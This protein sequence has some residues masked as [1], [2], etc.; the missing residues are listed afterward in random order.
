MI[1]VHDRCRATM[2]VA[3]MQ[4]HLLGKMVE[5]FMD[6]NRVRH[7]ITTLTVARDHRQDFEEENSIDQRTVVAIGIKCHWIAE[8]DHP[9]R[10]QH[11]EGPAQIF[12][13]I[14]GVDVEDEVHSG[15]EVQ[16]DRTL[17][18]A[19]A[20]MVEAFHHRFA[21]GMAENQTPC[22][23]ITETKAL[24]GIVGPKAM[25]STTILHPLPI[26]T[27]ANANPFLVS[28]HTANLL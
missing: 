2:I 11:I 1:A 6:A 10:F 28:P 26:E 14:E 15:G 19:T 8:A 25:A 3:V 17:E 22:H 7:T 18:E 9:F 4:G 24:V 13:T 16:V 12:M 27:N 21:I 23:H 5:N 20:T